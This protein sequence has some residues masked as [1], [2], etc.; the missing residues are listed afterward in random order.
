MKAPMV[1]SAALTGF[2]E[3]TR[4]LGLEPER[5][6]RQSGVPLRALTGPDVLIRA[7]AAF[8][9]MELA[10][11]AG[12]VADFGLRLAQPR[13]LSHLG[14]L[15]LQ[16]RDEQ[17]VR[18]ALRR[19]MAG[20]TLHSTCMVM[21]LQEQGETAQCTLALLADGE[22]EVRQATEAG[23]GLLF[24]IMVQLFGAAWRPRRV[25]FVHT[26]GASDRAYRLLFD[27]PVSFGEVNNA[28]VFERS[29]L[30]RPVPGADPGFQRFTG[31]R[32]RTAG[33]GQR[34]GP[35]AARQIIM[36]QLDRNACTSSSVAAE[37]GVHR[38]T[39]HRQL[40]RAG[41]DFS[42]L[43]CEAR[44]DRACAYLSAR[45]MSVSEIGDLLG[46][47]SVSAFSRWFKVQL[48]VAPSRWSV[49]PNAAANGRKAR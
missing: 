3:L 22:S 46:F 38:R 2:A 40:A 7:R 11:E 6:A 43:L 44:R 23:V 12:G 19:I 1:R 15:G 47:S 39:L 18:A 25:H 10:A 4:S 9:L 30:D 49:A 35:E 34:V 37:F 32:A 20:M 14:L 24:Q 17:T 16:V 5:L 31:T 48:G 28:V 21:D 27:C 13:G 29:D 42:A 36:R 41:T 45:S 26:R 8:R 33:V